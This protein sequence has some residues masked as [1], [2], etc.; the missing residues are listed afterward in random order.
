MALSPR[1][2]MA[3]QGSGSFG[4]ET[5]GP[6][7]QAPVIRSAS[8]SRSCPSYEPSSDSG[9]SSGSNS[10]LC[11][12]QLHPL[13]EGPQ[14]HGLASRRHAQPG[15]PGWL[16][17]CSLRQRGARVAGYGD[18]DG[19]ISLLR[20]SDSEDL[21][22][23]TGCHARS[24]VDG[25]PLH[26][27]RSVDIAGAAWSGTESDA[28]LVAACGSIGACP[29]LFQRLGVVSVLH[30]ELRDLLAFVRHV[31]DALVGL[32]AHTCV[33]RTPGKFRHS[34]RPELRRRDRASEDLL[35]VCVRDQPARWRA[36]HGCRGRG[37]RCRR[38]PS[39]ASAITTGGCE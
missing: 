9:S 33:G 29:E 5:V 14:D 13:I 32:S 21:D 8:S 35:G 1:R 28:D 30:H 22:I 11:H 27:D 18:A 37:P 7:H 34:L 24:K 36:C 12:D 39:G 3:L 38:K 23:V 31:A 4:T 6:R 19:G 2:G 15:D 17:G 10:C 26:L 20:G 25:G 16:A